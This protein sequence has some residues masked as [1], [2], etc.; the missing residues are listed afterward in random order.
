M[1]VPFVMVTLA[2]AT[3]APCSFVTVTATGV[4]ASVPVAVNVI[5]LGVLMTKVLIAGLL[6]SAFRVLAPGTAGVALTSCEAI[7]TEPDTESTALM[8][9]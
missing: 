4:F 8:V 1:P 3:V 9:K 6:V 7:V 5:V 2:V